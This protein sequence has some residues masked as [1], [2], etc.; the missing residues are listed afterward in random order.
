M[1]RHE[2]TWNNIPYTTRFE[3]VLIKKICSYLVVL[4]TCG[5]LNISNTT[6]WNHTKFTIL[7]WKFGKV[8]LTAKY[9]DKRS[10]K[11]T[12]KLFTSSLSTRLIQPAPYENDVKLKK[13]PEISAVSQL[14][15]VFSST[16][17]K[18][19]IDKKRIFGDATKKNEI[20]FRM[21]K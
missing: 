9:L 2:R 15:E 7:K 13:C 17:L 4:C 3:Y 16:P 19:K 6:H 1:N 12:I 21:N 10:E 20:D 8:R 14:G 5:L 11:K 18:W